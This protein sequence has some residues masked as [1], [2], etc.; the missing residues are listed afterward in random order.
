MTRRNMFRTV[1]AAPAAAVGV[2]VAPHAPKVIHS[3][4]LQQAVVKGLSHIQVTVTQ[5]AEATKATTLAM[6]KLAR[7]L[8]ADISTHLSVPTGLLK[9]K[10]P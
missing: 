7:Q 4:P 9:G 3:R 6:Q 5:T 8:T 2:H 1:L 10:K